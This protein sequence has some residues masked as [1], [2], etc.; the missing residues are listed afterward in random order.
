MPA[1]VGPLAIPGKATTLGIGKSIPPALGI[2]VDQ[3]HSEEEE[4][5]ESR[6]MGGIHRSPPNQNNA[7]P[8]IMA[9]PIAHHFW[10]LPRLGGKRSSLKGWAGDRPRS[11]TTPWGRHAASIGLYPANRFLASPIQSNPAGFQL[12]SRCAGPSQFINDF[13][14]YY[15][16]FYIIFFI[17][18]IFSLPTPPHPPFLFFPGFLFTV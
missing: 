5:K 6:I 10:A 4:N 7:P 16:I 2:S 8:V 12:A 11:N 1:A 13:Y 3:E 14:Y 18:S 15:F 17:Q 9:P